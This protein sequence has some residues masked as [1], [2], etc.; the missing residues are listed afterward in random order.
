MEVTLHLTQLLGIAEDVRLEGRHSG[1]DPDRVIEAA[2]TLR[3]IVHRLSGIASGRLSIPQLALPAG[4]QAARAACETALR[5]HLQSW[6]EVLEDE[7]GFDRHRAIDVMEHFTSDDL[8]V[9]LAALQE[10]LWSLGI[11]ILTATTGAD[12][13]GLIAAEGPEIVVLDLV[14]PDMDGYA[15]FRQIREDPRTCNTVMVVRHPD[16]DRRLLAAE[17]GRLLPHRHDHR[18]RHRDQ[19]VWLGE[20]LLHRH[21]Q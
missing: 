3:R 13:W 12:A 7:H 1:I 19:H 10:C 16:P 5:N 8:E 21:R 2:G 6:V 15:L 4:I 18:D 9:P 17:P 11:P 20:L 14:L